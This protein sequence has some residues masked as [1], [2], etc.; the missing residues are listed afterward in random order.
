METR[1][2]GGRAAEQAIEI[3]PQEMVLTRTER[4]TSPAGETEKLPA[5]QV[6]IGKPPPLKKTLTRRD[7]VEIPVIG[8]L[9]ARR[10][11]QARRQ[12]QRP[13]STPGSRSTVAGHQQ[14]LRIPS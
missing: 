14:R 8:W 1:R 11:Q 9:T 2:A 10:H 3:R 7:R 4:M 5:L 6:G 13:D 12:D